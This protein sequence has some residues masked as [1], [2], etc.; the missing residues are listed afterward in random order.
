MKGWHPTDMLH[1]KG[2]NPIQVQ[3]LRPLGVGSAAKGTEQ[4]VVYWSVKTSPRYAHRTGLHML[5]MVPETRLK[6]LPKGKDM[7]TTDQAYF[8]TILNE[9]TDGPETFQCLSIYFAWRARDAT[10]D[11]AYAKVCKY[12]ETG[13]IPVLPTKGEE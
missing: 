3:R 8:L 2:S 6:P 9:E 12:M 10:P 5:S 13:E 4:G 7:D 1:F 11:F